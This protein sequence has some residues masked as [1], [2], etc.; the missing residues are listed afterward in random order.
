MSPLSTTPP[1]H[2]S[3]PAAMDFDLWKTL[4]TEMLLQSN[5]I[6]WYICRDGSGSI[7]KW[8]EGSISCHVAKT[9][10]DGCNNTAPN[11]FEKEEYSGLGLNE[12]LGYRRSYTIYKVTVMA[13][14][15]RTGG[16]E[17]DGCGKQEGKKFKQGVTDPRGAWF[18]R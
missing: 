8:I 6:N 1:T 11:N 14:S 13:W 5:L 17:V 12:Y 18:V 4:G 3:L 10:V 16:Y 9:L 15:A 2:P 7:L